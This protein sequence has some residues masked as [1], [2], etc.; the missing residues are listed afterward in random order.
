MEPSATRGNSPDRWN[1]LLTS[2]DEKL[3]LGILDHLRKIKSYHFEE[4]TLFLE[5]GSPE[6][7][8]YLGKDTVV[9]QLQLLAHDAVRVERVKI[10][11]LSS[12]QG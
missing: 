4:D 7:E 11:K 6:Q 8:S 3:Q 5:P 9:Q 12:P 2:L 10:K 1:K